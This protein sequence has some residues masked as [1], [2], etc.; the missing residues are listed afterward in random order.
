MKDKIV[1][2]GDQ[3]STSEELLPGEG[4]FEEDGII[5]AARAGKYVVDEKHRKAK[6][7]SKTSNKRPSRLEKRR[8]CHC[9]GSYGKIINGHCKRYSCDRKKQISFW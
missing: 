3:L 1:M 2:P 7:K 9:T 4:T 8:Y 5:R 6:V